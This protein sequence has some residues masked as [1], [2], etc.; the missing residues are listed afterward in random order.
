[1]EENFTEKD[2]L[3]DVFTSIQICKLKSEAET[4]TKRCSRDVKLTLKAVFSY[5]CMIVMGH[6]LT[7]PEIVEVRCKL[8]IKDVAVDNITI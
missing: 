2:A 5:Y 7:A 3:T 8:R 4:A 6:Y 1:M